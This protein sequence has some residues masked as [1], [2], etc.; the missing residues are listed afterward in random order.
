MLGWF[1]P[2]LFR[3]EQKHLSERERIALA[4]A[5]ITTPRH[6]THTTPIQERSFV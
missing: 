2:L 1:T 5:F 6:L 4:V 3:S